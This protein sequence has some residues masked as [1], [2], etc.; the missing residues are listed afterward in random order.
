M[1]PALE[2]LVLML[3]RHAY[4][5]AKRGEFDAPATESAPERRPE[6]PAGNAFFAAAR[7]PTVAG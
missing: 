4:E 6:P 7:P 1:K 3:A 5:A 2:Q